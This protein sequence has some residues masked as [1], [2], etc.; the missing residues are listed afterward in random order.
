MTPTPE[1][2]AVLRRW[3]ERILADVADLDGRGRGAPETAHGGEPPAPAFDWAPLLREAVTAYAERD[4]LAFLAALIR[5]IPRGQA[6]DLGPLSTELL[7][8]L[9]AR[10]RAADEQ[11]ATV[12]DPEALAALRAVE[13]ILRGD[14]HNPRAG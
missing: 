10:L 1:D 2:C 4:P 6:V 8:A 3:I 12:I 11:A 14:D 5:A 7:V 13:Q 9:R